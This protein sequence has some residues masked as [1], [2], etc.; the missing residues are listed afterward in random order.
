MQLTRWT[1][2]RRALALLLLVLVSTAPGAMTVLAVSS[3]A[4]AGGHHHL[5]P[6]SPHHHRQPL[7]DCCCDLCVSSC[8]ACGAVVHGNGRHAWSD[9]A[10]SFLD[11]P[12]THTRFVD[13]S[14]SHRFPPP[15]GPP[16]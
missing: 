8:I 6:G 4:P 10:L 15:L 3:V 9:A 13:A 7:A 12:A 5:P 2:L 1:H 14:F 11:R 16:S